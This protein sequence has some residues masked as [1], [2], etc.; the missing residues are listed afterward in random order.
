MTNG[1]VPAVDWSVPE[2]RTGW[3]GAVDRFFGPDQTR[4]EIWVQ[5]AGGMLLGALVLA[6]T[7]QHAEQLNLRWWGWAVVAVFAVDVIGGVLTNSTGTA[8][9]WYHR[10]GA[11][12]ERLWFVTFH[13]IHLCLIAYLVLDADMAWLLLNAVA[14]LVAAFAV[15]FTAVELVRPV[16]TGLTVATVLLNIW[17]VPMPAGLEWVP[18]LFYVKL[19]L[20]HMTPEAPF[21]ARLPATRQHHEEPR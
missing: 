12:A 11:R 19:L 5:L 7:A 4:A 17:L 20:A 9:R 8:K 3:R 6:L 16:A 15:E 1:S 21:R 18:L 14:M 10:P 2:P 13:L